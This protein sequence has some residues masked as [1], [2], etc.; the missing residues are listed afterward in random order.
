MRV[1]STGK[2]QYAAKKNHAK[3]KYKTLACTKKLKYGKYTQNNIPVTR[4]NKQK[5]SKKCKISAIQGHLPKNTNKSNAQKQAVN[6]EATGKQ[7]QKQK[8]YK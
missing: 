3:T 7:K 5:R 6:G 1:V 8:I 2:R 4:K